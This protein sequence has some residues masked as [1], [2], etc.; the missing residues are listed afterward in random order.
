V[1]GAALVAA[2]VASLGLQAG[3]AP[4]VKAEYRFED[5]LASSVPAAPSLTDLNAS[6]QKNAF[7]TET[8]F[9]SARRV[10]TF[11]KGNGLQV[12]TANVIPMTQYTIVVV[13]RFN[14]TSGYRR[15]IDLNTAARNSDTGLYDHGGALNYYN[16]ASGTDTPITPSS[17]GDPYSAQR[18]G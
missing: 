3:P 12:S 5:T 15:I 7:A 1:H 10:L 2:A 8:V 11:P 17:S 9:G 16:F 14:D 13:F 18:G 4:T 6:G